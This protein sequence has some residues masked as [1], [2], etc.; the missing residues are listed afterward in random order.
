MP[1]SKRHRM[2]GFAHFA[3]ETVPMRDG[4]ISPSPEI[5]SDDVPVRNIVTPDVTHESE[6]IQ[7]LRSDLRAIGIVGEEDNAVLVYV[8]FTSRLLD[9]P[10]AIV[11]RGGSGTGKSTLL[12]RV[13][14]LFPDTAVIR[15]MRFTEA[16]LFN[17]AED[18]LTHK[19][20]I[21]GE[22]KHS[23][24]D[25]TRD[26]NRMIRQLLS[27]KRIT[28]SVSVP[29][30]G[31]GGPRWVTELQVRRGPVAYAESTTSG[32]IFDEDL[33]R[34]LE[35][36]MDESKNQTQRVMMAV[37]SKYDP[38]TGDE[39]TEEI[40]ARHHDFQRSINR[41]KVVI[42][43]WKQLAENIPALDPRC[44]RVAQQVFS[45][46]EAITLLH[47][48]HREK[49][50]KGRLWATREDYEL[51]RSLLLSP[52]HAALGIGPDYDAF[53]RLRK[54][55][56]QVKFDSNEALAHF[57][58]KMTRDRTLKK[59]CELGLL[60]QLVA[61]KSHQPARWQWVADKDLDSLVLPG[62]DQV[63]GQGD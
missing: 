9:D 49:D 16:S 32:T 34:M 45:V 20:L 23:T 1:K 15:F 28:R 25:A 48:H 31:D 21:T 10:L 27:E 51:T 47:Q 56:Q 24:D 41:Y 2:N 5:N 33:N 63:V 58:N 7:S 43:Y 39:S 26:G 57:S 4:G 62:V 50:T 40:T 29:G 38:D 3:T 46:V 12:E 44:R 35:L 22:R 37:A 59:F 19:I 14:H 11:T 55:I 54:S 6:L 60:K 52:L 17:M 36:Y 53:R 8:G 13:S 30:D 42:P 18:C 61:G